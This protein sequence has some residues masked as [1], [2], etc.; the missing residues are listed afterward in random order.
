MAM[1][2]TVLIGATWGTRELLSGRVLIC[3]TKVT[4]GQSHHAIL[5]FGNDSADGIHGVSTPNNLGTAYCPADPAI[6][7]GR[8]TPDRTTATEQKSVRCDCPESHGETG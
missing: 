3:L 8:Q 4:A 5:G 2:V 6:R 7:I 1:P